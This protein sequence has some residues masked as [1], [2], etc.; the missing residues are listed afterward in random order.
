MDKTNRFSKLSIAFSATSVSLLYLLFAGANAAN[1]APA[2]YD[3]FSDGKFMNRTGSDPWGRSLPEWRVALG[4]VTDFDASNGRLLMSKKVGRSQ[5]EADFH[6]PGDQYFKMSFDYRTLVPETTQDYL[7]VDIYNSEGDHFEWGR[8]ND[9]HHWYTLKFSDGSSVGLLGVSRAPYIPYASG[10]DSQDGAE[11]THLDIERHPDHK[12][13]IFVNGLR[14]KG[15]WACPTGVPVGLEWEQTQ[16]SNIELWDNPRLYHSFHDGYGEDGADYPD[17]TLEG[18]ITKIRIEWAH[19]DHESE[20]YAIDNIVFDSLEAEDN[21]PPYTS[22]H[23]PS[24]NATDVSIDTDITVHIIDDGEGIDQSSIVMTV[25][26]IPVIPTITGS[27]NDYT[28]TYAPFTSFDYGQVV[29]ITIAAQDL[30]GNIMV[31]DSYSFTIKP[32]DQISNNLI[33]HYKFDTGSG[34]IAYDSSENNNNGTLKNM[35]S[36]S[37][38]EGKIGD[39]SLQFDGINDYIDCGNTTSLSLTGA[40]TLETWIQWDG[41]ENPYFIT[42]MGG[43]G[44][45]SYDFSGNSD[46]TAEFRVGGSTCN[47]IFSTGAI[48]I[49]KNEWVHLAGTYEPSQSIKLYVN[50]SLAKQNTSSVPSSQCENGLNW[51]VGARQGNQGFFNGSIDNVKIYD[52]ALTANEIQQH[53]EEGDQEEPPEPPSYRMLVNLDLQGRAIKGDREIVFKAYHT[54]QTSSIYEKSLL[55]DDNDDINIDLSDFTSQTGLPNSDRYNNYDIKIHTPHYLDKKILNHNLVDNITSPVP[56]KLGDINNDN[57]INISD[58]DIMLA[59]WFTSNTSS[60]LNEDGIT[61]SLDLSWLNRN[62]GQVGD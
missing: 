20:Q 30:A 52:Y 59:N 54:G 1:A 2:F 56:M 7:K 55:T 49:P 37:W 5:L 44:D 24:K 45:R 34:T 62:W 31:Q 27:T 38:V 33:A 36:S 53:Y 18:E 47:S 48:S 57:I 26:D 17:V 16:Y 12:M 25:E 61:N 11:W 41:T 3:D 10:G 60:D 23:S 6:S 21:I 29:D 39:Y 35:S 19:W 40:I 28:V 43:S 15:A 13:Y 14:L 50:G 42:K 22:G 4:A 58:F 46:G 32:Q 8:K 51:Y 9:G